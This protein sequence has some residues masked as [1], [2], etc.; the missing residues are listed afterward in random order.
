VVADEVRALAARTQVSTAEIKETL[1][2]LTAGS[3][4]AISAMDLTQQTC[5]Q[6]AKSTYAVAEDL[7]HIANSVTQINDLNTQIATAAEQQSSVSHEVTRNMTAIREMAQELAMNGQS[8]AAESVN[9][10]VAND[11]LKSIVGQFKLK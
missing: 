11:Q 2:V 7:D 3:S 6:T 8:T 10:A 4:S 9:V 1:D 5:Q